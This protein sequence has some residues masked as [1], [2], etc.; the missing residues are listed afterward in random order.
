MQS[1]S[2]SLPTYTSFT[3]A[4]AILALPMPVSM[5]HGQLC[6]FLCTCATKK[7]EAYLQALMGQPKDEATRAAAL[8]L[9]QV[10]SVSQHQMIEGDFSFKL[11]LPEDEEELFERAQAFSEWCEG[12]VEGLNMVD[13][14]NFE[15]DEEAE[16]AL[17]HIR[18]FAALDCQSLE[19]DE[20]DEK[21][22]MEI[23]EFT[24]VAVLKLHADFIADQKSETAH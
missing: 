9:F 4:I 19:V 21:A 13:I 24:R 8:A 2:L 6:A 3:N 16:E 14:S 18:E 17:T 15:M 5:L 7:G 11:L 1:N 22:L 20:E 23:N 10:F 12:F